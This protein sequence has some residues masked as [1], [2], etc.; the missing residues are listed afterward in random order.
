MDATFE[1]GPRT[2]LLAIWHIGSDI[3]MTEDRI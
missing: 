2:A 3:A 1:I